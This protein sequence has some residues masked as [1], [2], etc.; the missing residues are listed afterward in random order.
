MK[1]NK[2]RVARCRARAGPAHRGRPA[3]LHRGRD[4]ALFQKPGARPH[5]RGDALRLRGDGGLGH[6][7]GRGGEDGQDRL[8]QQPL[9]VRQLLRVAGVERV[10]PRPAGVLPAHV[11]GGRVRPGARPAADGASRRPRRHGRTQPH[12]HVPQPPAWRCVPLPS[13]VPGFPAREGRCRRHRPPEAVQG[14]RRV[15]PRAPRL[16]P[17]AAVLDGKRRLP[18]HRCLSAVVPVREQPRQHRRVRRL[19]EHVLR[20]RG[21]RARVQ[22]M[23]AAARLGSVARLPDQPTRAVRAPHGRGVPQPAAHRACRLAVHGVRASGLQRGP[24]HE[25]PREGEAL[26]RVRPVHQAVHARGAGHE[27]RVVH[28][29]P[30]LHAPQ[31][32]GL[33]RSGAGGGQHAEAGRQLLAAAGPG[34][35]L[36]RAG[37]PGVLRLRAQ[38]P[39][40]GAGGHRARAGG[41]DPRKQGGG[42]VVRGRH[43]PADALAAGPHG[44]GRCRA[45]RAG[46]PGGARGAVLP[47]EPQG[48]SGEAFAA[49]RR[50]A[51]R[52]D[53]ARRVLRHRGRAGGAVPRAPAFH[54]GAGSS[55]A[56]TSGGGPARAR[57]AGS[58]RPGI[59]PPARRGRGGRAQGGASVGVREEG[60]SLRGAVVGARG[61]CAVRVR[62]HRG[63][64]GRVG[65]TGAQAAA[66]AGVGAGIRRSAEAFLRARAAVGRPCHRSA[67]LRRDREHR[68]E[69]EARE[70]VATAGA[71]VGA[72]G[73]GPLQRRHRR[74]NGPVAVHGEKPHGRRLPQAGRAHRHGRRPEGPRAGPAGVGFLRWGSRSGRGALPCRSAKE[75][76]PA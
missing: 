43:V 53:L 24:S 12:K 45:G 32:P 1:K 61:A 55:G 35:A 50:Q 56:G 42:A 69:E 33:L 2:G 74:G 67:P 21:S 25:H 73:A 37:H 54:D 58:V 20:G 27:H 41:Y 63:R 59:Q 68:A 66:Q 62:A 7:R 4:P 31:Q 47:A 13:S 5:G 3:A 60:R 70:A 9:P 11:G 57:L 18:R 48:A 26:P 71:G 40:R 28:A 34:V 23:P 10:G 19:P 49:R 51:R 46:R 22:G 72:A 30:P 6:R 44:R 36:H 29:Q 64:R 76:A 17:R 52:A 75:S 14:G 8:R 15:L 38:P 39:G 65:R 16:L